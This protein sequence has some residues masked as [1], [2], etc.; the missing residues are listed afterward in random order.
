MV[1][2]LENYVSD[3]PSD[4]TDSNQQQ[5]AESC[6]HPYDGKPRTLKALAHQVSGK[7]LIYID[8]KTGAVCKPC[9]ENEPVWYRLCRTQPKFHAF[10][11]V[12]PEVVDQFTL[13]LGTDTFDMK[14]QGICEAEMDLL[15]EQIQ[16]GEVEQGT[17]DAATASAEMGFTLKGPNDASDF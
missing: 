7:K 14:Q 5:Q 13:R 11:S 6:A 2:L 12:I 16:R 10:R 1:D 17:K 3:V 9:A 4:C 15:I 8:A